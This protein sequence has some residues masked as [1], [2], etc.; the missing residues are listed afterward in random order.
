MTPLIR[1][2]IGLL[3]GVALL[4]LY[5]ASEQKTWPATDAFVFAPL[6]TIATLVPLIVISALGHVRWRALLAWAVVATL[7]CAG[8]AMQMTDSGLTNKKVAD[9]LGVLRQSIERPIAA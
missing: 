7:L 9:S 4:M 5:Q 8:L 6:A 3:Q 2:A 1:L